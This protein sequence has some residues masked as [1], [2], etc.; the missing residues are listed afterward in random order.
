MID[1]K[2]LSIA[3]VN[4]LENAIRYNVQNGE[5]IVRVDPVPGKPFVRVSVKDTGI[6]IPSEAMAKLFKKFFRADNAVQS[7]TEGSG[8]GLYIAKNIIQAH[9]GEIGAESELGRGTTMSF[10]LPTD[11]NLV[12]KRNVASSGFVL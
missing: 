1:S 10:T 4:I 6:G 5:V 11:P 9:G 8:L 3:L 12:P 7:A 2:Q